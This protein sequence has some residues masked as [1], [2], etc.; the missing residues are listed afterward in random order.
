MVSPYEQKHL[1]L[2]QKRGTWKNFIH[3]LN[4]GGIHPRQI[5]AWAGVHL[6]MIRWWGRLQQIPGMLFHVQELIFHSCSVEA[7]E[8]EEA[9]CGM[10]SPIWSLAI[11]GNC[12]LPVEKFAV[13]LML[14]QSGII[15][16]ACIGIPRSVDKSSFTV[17]VSP[18]PSP[19]ILVPPTGAS[20]YQRQWGIV[21]KR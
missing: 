2:P 4:S 16:I 1:I 3:I 6:H 14:H 21:M 20:D 8:R 10:P 7:M 11:D 12:P 15:G 18:W 19:L 17:S 5:S 13:P 9:N